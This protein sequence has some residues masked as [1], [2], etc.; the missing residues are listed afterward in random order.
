M[1]IRFAWG[2][3]GI[4]PAPY[5]VQ[6]LPEGNF[7]YSTYSDG[8]SVNQ[9]GGGFRVDNNGN[10]P[11]LTP[12]VKTELEIGTDLRFFKDSYGKHWI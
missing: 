1:I 8:V 4:Q 9:F 6:N 10:D 7:G 5:R 3:V 12:E 11:N 2:Q